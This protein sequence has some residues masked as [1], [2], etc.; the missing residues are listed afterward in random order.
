MNQFDKKYFSSEIKLLAGVDEAGRGPLAGPVVAAAVIFEKDIHI[1]GIADSKTLSEKKREF[2]FEKITTECLSFSVSVVEHQIIDEINIL[3]ASLLAMKN[4]VENLDV[5]PDLVLIDGNK[6]FNSDIPVIPIV[7]GDA[8]SFSIG[9]ASILAK[10]TRDRL[11]RK[12]SLDYPNYLL[13]KNKGYPTLEHRQ[14]VLKFGP[15]PIH[16]KT[17]LKNLYANSE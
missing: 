15:S 7:K 2:L 4:A 1:D 16:R 14:A 3:N 9:A 17:F 11:M 6:C 13:E 12:Y 8:K 10:V 5:I